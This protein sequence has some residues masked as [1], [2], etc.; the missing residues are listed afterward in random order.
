MNT[1]TS[2]VALSEL[3]IRYY[4]TID[5]DK[6]QNFWCDYAVKG[7]A[8]IVGRFVKLATA[9]TGADYYVEVGFTSGAGSL[10]AGQTSGEIQTRFNKTDWTNYTETG[11]YSFDATKTAFADWS[12]VALF[13][14]GTRVWGT[15]P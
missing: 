9:K 15:E 2:S 6:A 8:N 4:Y 10:G 1:G 14:N 3:T 13:R 7:C 11:D 12:K 5:G